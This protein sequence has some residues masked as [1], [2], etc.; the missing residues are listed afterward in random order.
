MS[1]IYGSLYKTKQHHQSP[2]YKTPLE[3]Y[4][5]DLIDIFAG[6][7][8]E[9]LWQMLHPSKPQ[10][11]VFVLGNP[12]LRVQDDYRYPDPGDWLQILAS[13]QSIWALDGHWLIL[14]AGP[15]GILAYND[16]LSKRTLYFHESAERVFFTNYLPILRDVVHPQID[17]ARFGVYWH[18][19]YP[20]SFDRYAP[21]QGSYFQDIEMLGT[22]GKAQISNTGV[23]TLSSRSWTPDPEPYNLNTLME[24]MTLLP[25]RA[26]KKVTI[27]LS[28]GMDCRPL[29]AIYLKHKIAVN[30]ATLGSESSQDYLI[31]HKIATHF[32]LPFQHISYD[33][34]G[35]TWDQAIDYVQSRGVLF[36]PANSIF[37]G[38]YPLLAENTD[39][40][41]S[42][43]FG[44]LY[45]FRFMVAHLKS[46]LIKGSL[47]YHAIADYLYG[48]PTSFFAT[49]A[50][51][52]MHQGF[53]HSIKDEVAKMPSSLDMPNPMWMNL[54]L[55]RN[56]PRSVNMPNL[57]WIDQHLIDHMP[58][59]QSSIISGHWQYGFWNQ[60]NEKLHR[61]IIH[62]ACPALES[63]PLALADATAPYYYRQYAVKVKMWAY[64]RKR[65]LRTTSRAEAFLEKYKEQILALTRDSAIRNDSALDM[66]KLDAIMAAYYN[67]DKSLV[68]AMTSF[69][70]FALGK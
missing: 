32:G 42:G 18:S 37:M 5:S 6:G 21:S 39:V 63:F 28:G 57:A 52:Q 1:W 35:A 70:A 68:G 2:R 64:Y 51:R 22:G 12:I 29:L 14:I 3:E 65:P 26:G 47:D 60:M 7:K 45:R 24:N 53:W 9:T 38:Y 20:P 62:E 41:I 13:E 69:L 8:S 44:E 50:V 54:F 46:S 43:Y 31:A 4:H 27:G 25:Y 66:P 15:E 67:G 34:A 49:D 55:V 56:S 17:Y 33:A 30:V 19:M 23:M 40:Y 61:S 36:N 11:V 48:N 16:S 10:H 59:L 58:Y